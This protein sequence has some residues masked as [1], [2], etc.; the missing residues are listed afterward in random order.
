[1]AW[2]G[3]RFRVSN[4][5]FPDVIN[6]NPN[7]DFGLNVQRGLV[8]GVSA[9]HTFG[10][11]PIIN[12]ADG[13][14]T[15]WDGAGIYKGLEPTTEDFV[16]I[17]SDN[18]NDSIAGT[19]ARVVVLIGLDVN[20]IQ[21]TETIS[22]N[23]LTPV[24]STLKYLRMTTSIVT[25]A[26]SNGFNEGDIIVA[27]QTDPTIEF[28]HIEIGNNRSLNSAYTIPSGKV[29]YI[30]SGFATLSKKQGSVCEVKVLSRIQGSVFQIAEWFS[31][32]SQGSSYIQR[33]FNIPLVGLPSGADIAI[34]ANTDTNGVAVSAG[35]EIFLVDV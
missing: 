3:R 21:Q 12:T 2:T 5:V 6:N 9:V 27:Q 26:G 16:T 10:R 22:M 31:L 19:G 4:N 24:T 13:F 17:V 33:P 14:V 18:V 7:G 15:V 11:A 30:S 1:M 32:H 35:L 25:Q 28:T 34:L 20:F 23:G 8:A 29:G